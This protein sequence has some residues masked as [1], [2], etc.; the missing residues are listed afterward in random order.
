MQPIKVLLVE[1]EPTDAELALY[2][3][4][5]AQIDFISARV[6][7]REDFIHALE[8]FAPDV[9]LSDF[10]MPRFSGLEA[11]KTLR[12]RDQE[13]PF[14]FVSGTIPEDFAVQSL[15]EGAT[16]YVLKTN[17]RRLAAAV[18]RAIIEKNERESRRQMQAK[19]HESLLRLNLISNY[20]A[21]TSLPAHGA[22]RQHLDQ[23]LTG[24]TGSHDGKSAM[25]ALDI[26]RFH[27]INDSLGWEAGNILLDLFAKRLTETLNARQAVCR[28]SA[29]VFAFY[30]EAPE[31]ANSVNDHIYDYVLNA[32]RRPFQVMGNELR[33]AFKYGIAN[34]PDHG[35]N[36]DTLL[37]NAEMALA[38]A[39]NSSDRYVI[40]SPAMHSR[41]SE[42]LSLENK[43]RIAVADEQFVL[44]YQPK[45]DIS[46]KHLDGLEALIRWDSPELGR[47]SP[48][49]FIPV[50]EE[51]QLIIDVGKWVIQQ[52]GRDWRAWRE[53]GLTVP[54]IAVNISP[55]QLCQPDF[56]QQITL[57][58]QAGVPLDLE[59]TESTIME[60]IDTQSHNLA[61][62]R[63]LG[64][65]IDID[66][67]GTGYSSLSYIANLPVTGLKIDRSF[68][69]RISESSEN[70]KIA[71]AIIA[72]GRSLGLKITAE[73]VETR[74][75][76]LRLREYQC[77][78]VQGYLFSRP[79]PPQ[80]MA[81]LLSRPG[82]LVNT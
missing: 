74:E 59:I 33:L 29:D 31:Q 60:Q 69:T 77:D 25:V 32:L 80:Q 34:F 65:G 22:F 7:T 18:E 72:L 11:L 12:E 6:D 58:H 40:Y 73:G 64:I 2:E 63:E 76:W 57:A 46:G 26:E 70:S 79:L 30:C 38:K 15:K 82:Q 68:V 62:A 54:H 23:V 1:D 21:I 52:A 10:S 71:S 35:E 45:Y 78:A 43:L 39:K 56:M 28:I 3:L 9:V 50:L 75:Q 55:Q 5:K 19:L 4:S 53:Q 17:L 27:L 36:A 81:A 13:T 66:D 41:A 51:T 49:E 14:I 20:D 16:D 44:H 47:V 37:R 61:A 48:G 42:L 67:F 24:G 8:T